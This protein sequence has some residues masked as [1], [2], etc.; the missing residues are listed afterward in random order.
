VFLSGLQLL[1]RNV[2]AEQRQRVFDGMRRAIARG[3]GLTRH[4]LAFSRRR[5]VNPETIDLASHLRSMRELLDHTLGGD[6][7]VEMRLA[8][9]LWPVEL[10]VGEFE[11][12]MLNLCVNARDAMAA[13]ARS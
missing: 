1:E 11:L 8:A 6:I 4:L 3:S 7:H 5:P 12:A 10:D 13:A 9:D 2:N